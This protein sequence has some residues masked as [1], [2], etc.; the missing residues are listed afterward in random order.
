MARKQVNISLTGNSTSSWR[1]P[2]GMPT[3]HRPPSP[4]PW[5]LKAR[6]QPRNLGSRLAS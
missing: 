3:K 6:N 2:R 1:L 4:A 5:F